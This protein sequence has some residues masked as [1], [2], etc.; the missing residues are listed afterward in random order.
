[1]LRI[2]RTVTASRATVKLEGTLK[3]PW[4]TEVRH[5]CLDHDGGA[6]KPVALDLSGV[7][8]VDATGRELLQTLLR[9]GATIAACSSFVAELLQLRRA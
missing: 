9:N 8:F 5:A 4:V 6:E 1:M 7:T 2:T 3:E